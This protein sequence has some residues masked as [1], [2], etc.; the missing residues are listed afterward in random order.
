[1]LGFVAV[2]EVGVVFSVAPA[3]QEPSVLLCVYIA[4][5]LPPLWVV[6][7]QTS[8]TVIAHLLSGAGTGLGRQGPLRTLVQKHNFIQSLSWL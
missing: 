1:M 7:A 5:V 3:P 4:L 2:G 6:Q 8:G